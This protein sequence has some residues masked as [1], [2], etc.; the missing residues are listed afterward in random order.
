LIVVIGGQ[1]LK[2]RVMNIL[3]LKAGKAALDVF[4]V[5]DTIRDATVV[6]EIHA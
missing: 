1:P 2:W 4:G 5:A 6:E 3:T